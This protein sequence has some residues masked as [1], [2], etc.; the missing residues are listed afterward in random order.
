M[1]DWVARP[2]P[3]LLTFLD[4]IAREARH[5]WS[6]PGWVE[7]DMSQIDGH[8]A[9]LAARGV[10][11]TY[12][13]FILKAL[14][15]AIA[16]TRREIPEV[17]GMR[18]SF[19]VRRFVYFN[20]IRAAVASESRAQGQT[21]AHLRMIDDAEQKPLMQIHQELASQP[22]D[23]EDAWKFLRLPGF[24]IRLVL[25]LSSTFPKLA[26]QHRGSFGVSSVGHLGMAFL[27]LFN[28]N[29]AFSFGPVEPRAVV[30]E[31]G[32]E[33]R[34]MMTLVCSIDHRTMLGAA[35]AKLAGRA[36]AL[37]ENPPADW[38]A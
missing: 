5:Y 6:V 23:Q 18:I 32:I 37:L 33:A 27:P 22:R 2:W 30:R 3:S 36:K 8:R 16:E 17:N 4:V 14:A 7:V 35:S 26:W 21:V 12:Y 10:H 19:P 1:N 29:V 11:L 20:R 13:P 15:C 24:L 28:R 9:T 25:W 34:K 38:L 31:G